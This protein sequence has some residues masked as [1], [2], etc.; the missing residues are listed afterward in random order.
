MY[1]AENSDSVFVTALLSAGADVNAKDQV[2]VSLA[3]AI[4]MYLFIVC[5]DR[6]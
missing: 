4:C 5:I 1:A 2:R 3:I 6:D